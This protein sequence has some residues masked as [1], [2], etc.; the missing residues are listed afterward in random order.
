MS[1]GQ[2]PLFTYEQHAISTLLDPSTNS[3]HPTVYF[4]NLPQIF[5]FL[6]KNWLCPIETL[7]LMQSH[8]LGLSLLT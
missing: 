5:H 7:D 6:L 3:N 4:R 2:N 8:L 1:P